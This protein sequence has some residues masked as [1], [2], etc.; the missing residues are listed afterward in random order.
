[1]LPLKNTILTKYPLLFSKKMKD[2]VS[3]FEWNLLH[4]LVVQ[5]NINADVLINKADL[6]NGKIPHEQL[7]DISGID[8][9]HIGATAPEDENVILWLKLE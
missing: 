2:S 7:P 6:V 8:Q 5:A 3:Y 4:E 9:I 1:M